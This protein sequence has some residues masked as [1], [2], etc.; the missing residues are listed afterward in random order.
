MLFL[1]AKLYHH[2]FHNGHCNIHANGASALLC[3]RE[4]FENKQSQV[5]QNLFPYA[6]MREI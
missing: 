3:L 5:V 1:K 4:E 2:E 6:T